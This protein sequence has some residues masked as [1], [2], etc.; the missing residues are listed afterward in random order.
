MA[1]FACPVPLAGASKVSKRMVWNPV[2]KTVS[3]LAR[4]FRIRNAAKTSR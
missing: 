1:S 2:D 3:S 4:A